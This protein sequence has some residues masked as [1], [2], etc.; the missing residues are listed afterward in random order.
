MTVFATASSIA[1]P[2]K[3]ILS[4]SSLEYMSYAR[5]PCGDFSITV[6]IK[7]ESVALLV[8]FPFVCVM[9]FG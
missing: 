5:S 7:N 9:C 1:L 2:K 3:I 4:L 8:D 6:G